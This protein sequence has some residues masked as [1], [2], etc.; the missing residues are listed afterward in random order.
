MRT[1]ELIIGKVRIGR[2]SY[3]VVGVHKRRCEEEVAGIKGMLETYITGNNSPFTNLKILLQG[4]SRSNNKWC[5]TE[6]K[7]KNNKKII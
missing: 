5:Y 1:E 6:L 4:L 3:K 7:T 2:E